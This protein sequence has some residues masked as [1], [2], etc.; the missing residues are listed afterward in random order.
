M[1]Q[2]I[3]PKIKVNIM[4]MRQLPEGWEKKGLLLLGVIAIL[5]G[6]YAYNPLTPAYTNDSLNQT[7]TQTIIPIPFSQSKISANNSSQ[8]TNTN[9]NGTKLTAEQAKK[10]A[11]QSRPGYTAGQPLQG[12]VVV[13]GTTY[14]V[15]I[16]PLSQNIA[17]SKTIYI[18]SNTG[19]IVLEI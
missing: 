14:S 5:V 11:S 10:I 7:S 3:S 15:W 8:T 2:F 4:D 19:I 1:E 17:V 6:V 12:S 18:D 9:G 13:N 16:V